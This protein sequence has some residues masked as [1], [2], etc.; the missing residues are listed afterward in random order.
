MGQSVCRSRPRMNDKSTQ[1]MNVE[2]LVVF[3]LLVTGN[4]VRAELI[5]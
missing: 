4:V 3:L 5:S 2:C 1:H